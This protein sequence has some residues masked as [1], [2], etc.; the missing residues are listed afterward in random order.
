MTVRA[1]NID[2]YTAFSLSRVPSCAS[3]TSTSRPGFTIGSY[4]FLLSS[5]KRCHVRRNDLFPVSAVP[6]RHL[7]RCAALE[8]AAKSND[9]WVTRG[10]RSQDERGLNQNSENLRTKLLCSLVFVSCLARGW[11]W[12]IF[13][14]YSCSFPFIKYFSFFRKVERLG[15]SKE[16][17]K[18]KNCRSPPTKNGSSSIYTIWTQ[19]A[20]SSF[21]E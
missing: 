12:F 16:D 19:Y 15:G 10:S 7:V 21:K 5:I 11:R 20:R 8:G 14:F 13:C 18:P 4:P 3:W 6:L 1:V 2:A 17:R 9:S